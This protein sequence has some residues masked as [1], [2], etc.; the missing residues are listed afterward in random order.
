MASSTAKEAAYYM[1]R[2]H[3]IPY[4]ASKSEFINRVPHG[5]RIRCGHNPHI[6]ARKVSELRIEQD[7]E[8]G[9]EVIYWKEPP[10]LQWE[11]ERRMVI[12]ISKEGRLRNL[13][14]EL[15]PLGSIQLYS[16]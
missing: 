11:D 3:E 7:R 2:P 12:E 14:R 16:G 6:Y 9:I 8:K 4:E 1:N 13:K 5:N 10:T 15:V